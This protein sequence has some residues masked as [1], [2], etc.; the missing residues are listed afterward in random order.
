MRVSPSDFGWNDLG[1]WESLYRQLHK[2]DAENAISAPAAKEVD[3][4]ECHNL[5]VK[6][7]SPNKRIVL[8]GVEDMLVVDTPDVLFVCR[9]GDEAEMHRIIQE[10]QER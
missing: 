1:T 5:L 3:I 7:S 2:D 8:C 9:R 6:S 4:R 10:K